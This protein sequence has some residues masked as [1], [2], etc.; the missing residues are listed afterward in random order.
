MKKTL[1]RICA[2]VNIL[3]LFFMLVQPKGDIAVFSAEVPFSFTLT[4]DEKEY[5]NTIS[6]QSIKLAITSELMSFE[7]LNGKFGLLRPLTDLIENEWGLTIEFESYGWSEIFEKLDDGEVDIV[8]LSILSEDRKEK[9]YATNTLYTSNLDVY[10]RI[11]SPLFSITNLD[12][13]TIGIIKGSIVES[14]LGQYIST[15]TQIKYYDTID[16]MFLAL[17]NNE[18]KCV[19]SSLNV[20]S[21]LLRYSDI[22]CEMNVETVLPSEGLYAKDEKWEKLINIINRYLESTQGLDMLENIENARY[23]SVLEKVREFYADDIEYIKTHYEKIELYDSGVMYPFHFVKDGKFEGIL[24]STNEM[25]YKLTGK[26][27]TTLPSADFEEGFITALAKIK[28]GEIVGAT[29]VYYNKEYDLDSSYIYSQPLYLDR[30]QVY[31]TKEYDSIKGLKIASTKFA[32]PYANWETFAGVE[33]II[34][35]DRGEMLKALRNGIVDAV[36]VSEMSV[37]YN[38]T[39]LGDYSFVK[40]IPYGAE[41]NVHMIAGSEHEVFVKLYN[42]ADMIDKTLNMENR[43]KWEDASLNDKYELFRVRD[44][45]QDYQKTFVVVATVIILVLIVLLLIINYNYHK[46]SNYDRQISQMLSVQKNADMIWGD[47]KTRRI[48]SKG[49]FPF[50]K[51][52]GISIPKDSDELFNVFTQEFTDDMENNN[53]SEEKYSVTERIFEN[54]VDHTVHHMRQYTHNINDKKF[55]VFALDVTD[56]KLKEEYLQKL[57]NTDSL[58]SLLT[59]RAMESELKKYIDKNTDLS[60]ENYVLMIDI[61]DFKHVNDSYGHDI[62]DKALIMVANTIKECI[63]GCLVSR[64]GGEEFLACISCKSREDA[65]TIAEGIL[66][67][68]SFQVI[69]VAYKKGFSITVSCGV[70]KINGKD[71]EKAIKCADMALYTAKNEGKNCVRYKD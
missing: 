56:E 59:R 31:S 26:N 9:Y 58:S 40:A 6:N 42:I 10:T 62:G 2:Y 33:P 12:N 70:A 32:A 41:A 54:E 35:G 30:V 11:S 67:S 29:S 43:M 14:Y 25:F 5:L 38:Y 21:E 55:M 48:I 44:Q 60:E 71:Y 24:E 63:S 4:D 36:F 57:A 51:A 16:D 28:T 23:E 7:T 47:K 64:W 19:I 52:W 66:K 65:I 68:I 18:V 22:V 3:V 20:Q 1:I 69:H 46:F 17:S 39:I 53:A 15:D 49:D 50:L 8:G 61:D 34:Y 45:I 37:D 27:I 13:S